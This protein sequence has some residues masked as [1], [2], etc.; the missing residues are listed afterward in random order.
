MISKKII[1]IMILIKQFGAAPTEQKLLQNQ[2][3]KLRAAFAIDYPNVGNVAWSKHPTGRLFLA[4][5]CRAPEQPFTIPM[6]KEKIH[7]V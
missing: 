3:A 1:E 7:A 4:A 6:S 5:D 2:S